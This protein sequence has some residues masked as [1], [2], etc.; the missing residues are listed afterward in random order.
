MSASAPAVLLMTGMKPPSRWGDA[1]RRAMPDIALRE[2]PALGDP[3]EVEVIIVSKNQPEP[4]DAIRQ[5]PNLRGALI[6][7]AGVDH[8]IREPTLATHLPV[9]RLVDPQQVRGITEYILVTVIGIHRDFPHFV[10]MKQE[11]RWDFRF[12][13]FPEERRIGFMGYGSMVQESAELL[14]RLGYPVNLWARRARAERGMACFAGAEGLHAFLART[15]ILLVSLPLT[16]ATRR[17]LDAPALAALPRG[18][19]LVNIGRGEVIDDDALLAALNSGH[20]AEATLDVFEVEPLRADHPYWRHPRVMITPHV[21][22]AP[23]PDSAAVQLA[24]DVRRLLRGEPP[25][26]PVD[27]AAGY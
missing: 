12:P 27:R 19:S 8:L 4:G 3:R 23:H 26:H 15:D 10:R 21:A 20:V 22:G 2:W 16:E 6:L 17:I 18:A 13:T 14:A 25:A 5:L 1:L 9:G 11:G 7:G 24:A